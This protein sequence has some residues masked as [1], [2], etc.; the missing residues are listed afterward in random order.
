LKLRALRDSHSEEEGV[1]VGM[2]RALGPLRR[3]LHDAVVSGIRQHGPDALGVVLMGLARLTVGIAVSATLLLGDLILD[4]GAAVVSLVAVAGASAT[5]S[6]LITVH[7]FRLA[8]I[9]LDSVDDLATTS[10]DD[11]PKDV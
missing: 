2:D 6:R 3:E 8:S 1:D 5:L 11:L 7:R 10:S 9:H 4:S